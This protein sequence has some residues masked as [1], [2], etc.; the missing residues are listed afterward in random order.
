MLFCSTSVCKVMASFF[1]LS[2]SSFV[3]I[4]F[5]F[6]LF[7]N[8]VTFK[9]VNGRKLGEFLVKFIGVKTFLGGTFMMLKI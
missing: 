8:L 5:C 6:V 4:L 1:F 3:I 9:R 7:F 2:W